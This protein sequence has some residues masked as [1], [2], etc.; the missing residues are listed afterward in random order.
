MRTRFQDENFDRNVGIVRRVEELATKK[1]C[2]PA[3]LALAWLLHQGEDIITIPGST[4]S[5]RVEENAAAATLVLSRE[6][7]DSL[8]AVGSL[9]SGSRYGEAA[10]KAVNR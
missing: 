4:R 3:Q 8:N 7:I 10:M 6:E 2:A 9:V 1:G 5:E